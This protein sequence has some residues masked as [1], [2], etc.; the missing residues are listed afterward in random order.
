MTAVRSIEL[1]ASLTRTF[2]LKGN[3]EK[4][5]FWAVEELIQIRGHS[6]RATAAHLGG[7]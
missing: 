7:A 5:S 6:E 1:K 2:L 3:V 4:Y